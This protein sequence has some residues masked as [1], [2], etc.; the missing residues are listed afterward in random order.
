MKMQ[1]L[2][3]KRD[4]NV[5]GDLSLTL[6]SIR[7]AFDDQKLIF[8]PDQALENG[9]E[10]HSLE[11]CVWNGPKCLKSTPSLASLYSE[12]HWLMQGVLRIKDAD[13]TTLVYEAQQIKLGDSI[14]YISDVLIATCK[15]FELAS[16]ASS[17]KS[18]TEHA[19]FPVRK[20]KAQHN[21]GLHTATVKESWFI[22]DRMHLRK[23][24]EGHIDLLVL[25]PDTIQA[26]RP[27]IS[28][29]GLDQRLLSNAARGISKPEGGLRNHIE[30]SRC[31]Q[32]K[33]RFI[34]RLVAFDSP[35]R[36]AIFLQL[37]KLRVHQS[38]TILVQWVVTSNNGELQEGK[39]EAGRVVV[40]A[41]KGSVEIYLTE[42]DINAT[43][44][45]LELQEELALFADIKE[46]KHITLLLYILAQNDLTLIENTLLRRGVSNE[47]PDFDVLVDAEEGLNRLPRKK[48]IEQK[49]VAK[50]QAVPIRLRKAEF[51]CIARKHNSEVD[52][53]IQR[54]KRQSD[55]RKKERD[56]WAISDAV[57]FFTKI[58]KLEGQEATLLLPKAV[59]ASDRHREDDFRAFIDS[60]TT[61]APLTYPSSVTDLKSPAVIQAVQNLD[62]GRI[63]EETRYIGELSVATFL[64]SHLGQ[65]FVPSRH[66]TSS[67]RSRAGHVP[68]QKTVPNC[69]TFTL[70]D[71]TAAFAGILSKLG[72]GPADAWIKNWNWQKTCQFHIEVVV[73]TGSLSSTF[74][75][76][77]DHIEMAR[78]CCL[79]NQD[80]GFP[81]Q[82]FLI[83][84]VYDIY[85]EPGTALF[86]DPWALHI[87]GS[88]HLLAHSPYDA[89]FI[90][91]SMALQVKDHSVQAPMVAQPNNQRTGKSANLKAGVESAQSESSSGTVTYFYTKLRTHR[92]IRLLEV[93]P[94]HD[95]MPLKGRIIHV[96]I[97]DPGIYWAV[98]YVWGAAIKPMTFETS[99]GNVPITV[100]L[101]SALHAI[102]DEKMSV[103]LWADAICIDQSSEIE[104]KVQIRL[105]RTIFQ[106]AE[107]VVAWIGSDDDSTD[108]ALQ[109]LLQIRMIALNPKLWP[110]NLPGIPLSWSGRATP[111]L[112]D[113]VWTDIDD[114]FRKDYFR[115]SWIVQE[116][117]LASYVKV[118]CGRW[119]LNWDDLFL[120]LQT[121][122][123]TVLGTGQQTAHELLQHSE[124]AYFL[125]VTR[126]SR[127]SLSNILFSRKFSLLD[128]LDIFS[129]TKA[130]KEH[131]KLFSLLGLTSTSEV[132]MSTI[133]DKENT[134]NTASI[135]FDPDYE[136]SIETVVRRYA[137]EFVKQG[138]GME[139]LQKSGSTKAYD[140]CSWIPAWTHGLESRTISGWG[141][142]LGD[143]AAG[144][145]KEPSVTLSPGDP[146][147]LVAKGFIFDKIAKLGPVR[148]E[149]T[150]IVSFVDSIHSL[151]DTLKQNSYPTAE[152]KSDLKLFVP[153][154]SAFRP[155]AEPSINQ[156]IEGSTQQV[157]ENWP[158]NMKDKI[159]KIG[160]MHEMMTFF[161]KKTAAERDVLW[162]YW[163]TAAAFA[164]K[165]NKAVP[166]TTAKGYI[167]LI[168]GSAKQ[169]DLICI[170]HGSKSPFVLRKIKSQKLDEGWDKEDLFSLIG[171]AYIHGVMH[172][173]A[174]NLQHIQAK[175]IHLV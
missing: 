134:I 172:G 8:W 44:P 122:R 3:G 136:S 97:D 31:L 115:R 86:V 66:W 90:D 33:V 164:K 4:H 105:L 17:V 92:E 78:Q 157:L 165:I 142:N 72:Y 162:K 137:Q 36:Q 83:A 169:G 65:A 68:Y 30:Y 47:L 104:K 77:P 50:T 41:L 39:A 12:H 135:S 149:E 71:N 108:R 15:Y 56:S 81:E 99:N 95:E 43:L 127:Q 170:L 54:L 156:R 38:E 103:F 171:E 167:G 120:A 51:P 158:L 159:P 94:G 42:E 58:C 130:T 80:I 7:R 128:L 161:A 35:R 27:L 34:A 87:Q 73:A 89:K 151:I 26:I 62:I 153:I 155:Y 147:I 100:S 29:L 45:P 11:D 21:F 23:N 46:P 48:D 67:L 160:S 102:R 61:L 82:V 119:T 76:H 63:D 98:S 121:C 57:G 109:T 129:Y 174:M 107:G 70:D 106:S 118:F 1:R 2:L 19:I 16:S 145:D 101:H 9:G 22:A 124:P 117:V 79:L 40:E 150:D 14:E 59:S 96:S 55:L 13:I 140:F 6:S 49:T 25:D 74:G 146:K 93:D 37:Q 24:F 111:S 113:T 152:S 131:D 32:S 139:L 125:G 116:L 175:K 168:P 148:F 141:A 28:A 112:S 84:C 18:L 154:G 60:R 52:S 166:C 69:S 114:F 126:Q 110:E 163:N 85:S 20:A 132:T 75:L 138:Y 123:E 143:F 10:W 144:K 173:E 91:L 5:S 88:L 64:S 53:F 133:E